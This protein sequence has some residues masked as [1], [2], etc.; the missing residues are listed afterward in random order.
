MAATGLRPGETLA[1]DRSDVDLHTGILSIRQTKFALKLARHGKVPVPF[2]P[3]VADKVKQSRELYDLVKEQGRS[4]Y[5]GIVQG[6]KALAR[7]TQN[8]DGDRDPYGE[9]SFPRPQ[10][11]G[12]EVSQ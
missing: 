10:P 11:V 2:P 7:V 9:G 4:G 8:A 12:E 1:L 6:E 3:H 5:A